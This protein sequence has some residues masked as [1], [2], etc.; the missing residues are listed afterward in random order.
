MACEDYNVHNMSEICLEAWQKQEIHIID[1]HCYPKYI[2]P[3]VSTIATIWCTTN[4]IVGLSGNLLTLLAIPYVTRLK[5]RY[6]FNFYTHFT[7]QNHLHIYLFFRFNFVINWS[8]TVFILNL[9]FNDVLYCACNFTFFVIMFVHKR[10]DWGVELCILDGN[11]RYSN[12]LGKKT[13]FSVFTP[14]KTL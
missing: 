7:V 12:A 4:S 2:S 14:I 3:T 13:G 1:N 9:A 8:T 5:K 11:I 6:Y 10:F